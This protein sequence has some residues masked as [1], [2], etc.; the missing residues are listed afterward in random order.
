MGGRRSAA[1][2]E[3][4][5]RPRPAHDRPKARRARAWAG[6]LRALLALAQGLELLRSRAENRDLQGRDRKAFAASPRQS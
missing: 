6:Q 2:V 3:D 1:S 4:V 5:T